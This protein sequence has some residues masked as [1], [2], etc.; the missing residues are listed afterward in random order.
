[1]QYAHQPN[2]CHLPVNTALVRG[3][4]SVATFSNQENV[5]TLSLITA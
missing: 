3:K 1:M 4:T 5:A 2:H